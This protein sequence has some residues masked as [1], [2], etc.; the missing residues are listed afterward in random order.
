[1]NSKESRKKDLHDDG[2]KSS[3]LANSSVSASLP[4][5]LARL[6]GI[7]LSPSVIVMSFPNFSFNNRAIS[8]LDRLGSIPSFRRSSSVSL[9]KSIFFFPSFSR[10]LPSAPTSNS[11]SP[12][13]EMVLSLDCKILRCKCV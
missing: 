12:E 11:P 9:D 10:I 7:T 4:K 5:S 1:M 8:F 6:T 3:A 13:T 2:S